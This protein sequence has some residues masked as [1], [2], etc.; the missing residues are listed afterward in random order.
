M[1]EYRMTAYFYLTLYCFL[2]VVPLIVIFAMYYFGLTTLTLKR[3]FK[4]NIVAMKLV[5]AVF[6]LTMAI[7]MIFN[8]VKYH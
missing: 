6:F 2:F 5:M 8:G 7:F 4:G 3:F 1:P